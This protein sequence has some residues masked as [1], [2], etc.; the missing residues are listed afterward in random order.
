MVIGITGQSGAGKTTISGMFLEW[1]FVVLEID[2]I[3]KS[4]INNNEECKERIKDEFGDETVSIDGHIDRKVLAEYAFKNK[5]TLNKL[6]KITHP[7]VLEKVRKKVIDLEKGNKNII[8][9]AAALFESG[10]DKLCDYTLFVTA[11]EKD[12]LDRIIKR[13]KISKDMAFKR[14]KSQQSDDFYK[15]R[16]DCFLECTGNRSN[17]YRGLNNIIEKI[18]GLSD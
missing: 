11:P 15:S 18:G 6:S 14:I 1:G 4:A 9:D 13:D 5:F 10:M 16:C 17:V 3:A 12:R 2:L 7:Y 8:I